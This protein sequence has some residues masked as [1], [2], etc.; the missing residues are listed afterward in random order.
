MGKKIFFAF[1][2]YI[3]SI[4]AFSQSSD[5]TATTVL[6][7]VIVT[8]NKL[9]Q[10]QSATGK[11][12]SVITR[13]Q[14]ERSTGRTLPQLLN[15]Q[16]GITING[17]SN[18]IGN[19]QTLYMRGAPSGR[20][21]ILLDGIPV[22]DPS[23]IQN[24]FDINL[25]SLN[26]IERIEISRG[27][28]S[29]LYGSDAIAGVINIITLKTDI[30]KP[31]HLKATVAAGNYGT[32]R[33]NT[34]LY[35]R[36]GK[37]TYTTRYAKL[38]TNGFSSAYDSTGKGRFEND[39]YHGDMTN[40]LLQFRASEHWNLKTYFSYSNY[41]TDLDNSLFTDERDYTGRSK[42]L[43]T[44][45]GVYY[46]KENL[47]ITA[48]Y[49][50]STNR[51]SYLNDSIHIAGFSSFVQDDYNGSTQFLEVFSSIKLSTLFTLLQGAD[52][53][54]NK[55][56]SRYLSLSSFG[57]YNDS[58]PRQ[59]QSQSSLYASLLLHTPGDRLNIEAGG[60]LNVHSTYGSNHTFTFNPSY[61]IGDQLR[62]FG[63]IATGFKAPTLY[64]LYSFTYGDKTLRPERSTSYEAGLQ[65]RH[66]NISTRLVYFHR[67][68]NDG[69]DFD[70]A[71]LKYLNFTTQRVNGVEL[72]TSIGF[73]TALRLAGNYTYLHAMEEAQS[74][75]T[76]RDTTYKHLLRRP[77]HQANL[78]ATYSF[79]NGISF[80]VSGRYTGKRYD[81]GGF[82]SNDVL[83][84]DY[85]VLNAYAEWKIRQTF[86][87]FVD[88]QNITNTRFFDI[89]GYNSI[90]VLVNAGVTVHL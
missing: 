27:A 79:K 13:E 83:L 50:F 5:T 37:F 89:R 60:R 38:L 58:F 19:N 70:N 45:A 17:A 29:T 80:S 82:M 10:K 88:A 85:V 73:G 65:H 46:K 12:V 20:A 54:Q 84:N 52:Y 72:E 59:Q 15:E 78:T 86:T 3:H 1:L 81:A 25:L 7:E 41:K 61:K 71:N 43:M 67:N 90:P 28:Q 35:G 22:S 44:G 62:V 34:Q 6:D 8:A 31:V 2:L 16:A 66:K 77:R 64:Q 74:R 26:N 33:G 4:A 36:L 49:Q 30:S 21:V 18:A 11:V 32:F 69:I 87:F 51:R 23:Y 24:D 75:I 68:I 57:P 42:I 53:R 48:N 76:F 56:D 40:T 55:M 39:G 14:L 63:S 9:P 47:T